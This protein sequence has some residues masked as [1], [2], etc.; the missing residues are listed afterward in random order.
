MGKV[1]RVEGEGDV[2]DVDC[3]FVDVLQS[4]LACLVDSEFRSLVG[5]V[6]V[7]YA[8]ARLRSQGRGRLVAHVGRDAVQGGGIEW[9][10]LRLDVAWLV[11]GWLG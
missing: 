10:S 4:P 8:S 5:V 9:I 1:V 7:D 6:H 11:D 2:V 3:E